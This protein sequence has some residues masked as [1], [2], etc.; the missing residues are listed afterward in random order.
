MAKQ[1]LIEIGVPDHPRASRRTRIHTAAAGIIQELEE[2]DLTTDDLGDLAT[3]ISKRA[4][5]KSS[6]DVGE[7]DD[8]AVAGQCPACGATG[9]PTDFGFDT[10]DDQPDDDDDQPDD[11][12]EEEDDMGV[13][14]S[15]RRL[16]TL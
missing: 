3:A 12:D 14:E 5:A 2:A 10:S 13:A 8:D 1:R 16:I 4:S 6:G 7:E 15:T 9:S 11:D